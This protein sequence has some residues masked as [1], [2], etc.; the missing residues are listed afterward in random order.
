MTNKVE[1][2]TEQVRE[3]AQ[4]LREKV[5]DAGGSAAD[6]VRENSVPLALIGA[7]VGWLLWNRRAQPRRGRAPRPEQFGRSEVYDASSFQEGQGSARDQASRTLQ[8][9]G[10]KV[11][12][13]L[14]NVKSAASEQAHHAREKLVNWEH[15][16]HDKAIQVRDF[17]DHALVEQPLLLGAVALGAGL[18][19]GLAIPTTESENQLI[20]QYRDRLLSSAKERAQSLQ[21]V[22][23]RA[24]ET[25]KESVQEELSSAS[26]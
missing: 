5:S 3:A 7:G 12:N 20:G 17:A 14:E 9:I 24:V 15:A 8:G 13:G 23:E 26:M 11:S 22:A 4:H 19:V 10:H 16:A 1:E 18:A 6:F 25:A 2:G 21:G